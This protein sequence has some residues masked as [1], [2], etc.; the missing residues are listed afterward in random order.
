MEPKCPKCD[1][2][3]IEPGRI[4]GGDIMFVPFH[5]KGLAAMT[6]VKLEP[7]VCVNCGLVMFMAD[8]EALMRKIEL[9]DEDDQE[10]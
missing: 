10:A 6:Q 5:A 1:G 7:H 4:E 8:A 2:G 9:P 3:I